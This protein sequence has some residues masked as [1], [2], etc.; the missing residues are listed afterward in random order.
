MEAEAIIATCSAP[1]VKV[2]QLRSWVLL[3]TDNES[4]ARL[5]LNFWRLPFE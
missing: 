4:Y 1:G 3:A 2:R 5:D